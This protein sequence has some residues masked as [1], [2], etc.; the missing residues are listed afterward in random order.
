MENKFNHPFPL[1]GILNRVPTKA[2]LGRTVR[3]F[4]GSAQ[5]FRYNRID[6]IRDNENSFGG[7]IIVKSR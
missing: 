4:N 2:D 5:P 3:F 7:T 1:P 6:D